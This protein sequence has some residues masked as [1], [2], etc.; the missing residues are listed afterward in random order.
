MN[1]RI[2]PGRRGKADH[3][4]RPTCLP[5]PTARPGLK[6]RAGRVSA[7]MR[8]IEPGREADGQTETETEAPSTQHT[9]L[10]FS[11]GPLFPGTRG[12]S[13]NLNSP[14][15]SGSACLCPVAQGSLVS[16]TV[17]QAHPRPRRPPERVQLRSRRSEGRHALHPPHV[18]AAIPSA[19]CSEPNQPEPSSFPDG[20]SGSRTS[21]LACPFPR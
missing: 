20:A 19:G 18:H 11:W 14:V 7:C 9:H 3:G 13:S 6:S 1:R 16:I 2:G 5:G 10:P 15:A 8:V 4:R 17:M 21:L 12:P